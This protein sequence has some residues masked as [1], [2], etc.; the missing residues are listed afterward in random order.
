MH[1]SEQYR[2]IADS[3][4]HARHIIGDDYVSYHVKIR[5]EAIMENLAAV[6]KHLNDKEAARRVAEEEAKR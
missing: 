4:E 3:H 6:M 2:L 5:L 1:E